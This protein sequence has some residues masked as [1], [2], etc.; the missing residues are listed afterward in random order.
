MPIQKPLSDPCQPIRSDGLSDI[1][2]RRL[3][4]RC[5]HRGTQESDLVLGSFADRRL[6]GMDETQLERFEDLLDCPDPD[7]FEWI[8]GGVPPPA[9]H[10]HDVLHM[11]RASCIQ[12]DLKAAADRSVPDPNYTS[13]SR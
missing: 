4:F 1:R 9:E 2:R 10:D 3:L 13:R 11:L 7:L 12:R 5:W 6:A 8:L